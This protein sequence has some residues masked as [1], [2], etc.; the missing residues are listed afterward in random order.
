M[1]KTNPEAIQFM[2][3]MEANN[4]KRADEVSSYLRNDWPKPQKMRSH[5]KQNLDPLEQVE[6]Y[7]AAML[8]Q[9]IF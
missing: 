9:Q 5:Q 1:E 2:R 6:Q 4:K 3:K 7:G 8:K